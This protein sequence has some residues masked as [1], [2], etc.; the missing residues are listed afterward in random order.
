MHKSF[1]ASFRPYFLFLLFLLIIAVVYSPV[2]YFDYVFHDDISILQK[3]TEHEFKFYLYGQAIVQCRYGQALLL[4]LESLIVHKVSELNYLR[5]L[6]IVIS[7]CNASLL[8]RLMRRLSFSDI[9]AFLI[10][11]A[12]F[13]LPGFAAIFFCAENSCMLALSILLASWSFQ[14]IEIGK[15][16]AVSIFSFFICYY[17]LST[18]RNVLL[19]D[20]RHVHPVCS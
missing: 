13:L 19:D 5:F 16:M 18:S 9:Q 20:G 7:S 3:V 6:G 14:R 12:M 15:K 10:I 11:S 4:T 2:L 8:W 1:S 17:D